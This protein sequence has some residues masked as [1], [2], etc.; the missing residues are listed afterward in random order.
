MALEQLSVL[1]VPG[2]RRGDARE[3]LASHLRSPLDA[4][5]RDRIIA[6]TH[7]NPLALLELSRGLTETQLAGGFWLA[8]TQP[9]HTRIEQSFVRR[10]ETLSDVARRL[11]LVAAAEPLGDPLLVWRAAE[12][13]QIG[14]ATADDARTREL[15]AMGDRVVFRH[16]LVRSAVYGSAPVEDRRA[17]HHALAE[18][19]DREADPDRRAWHLAAAAA[20]PDEQVAI[21]LERS[22]DRAQARGGV[23]AS[24]AFLERAVALSADMAR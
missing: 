10:F 22:A 5:V 6:E 12:R 21:E 4:Q 15:L 7:G 8:G 3:L 20:G 9:L 19:T 2:L 14:P 16:P 13:L 23:A 18:V 11:L 17:V 1:D 24:A